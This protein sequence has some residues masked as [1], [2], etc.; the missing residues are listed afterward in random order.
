MSCRAL[1]VYLGAPNAAAYAPQDS[2]IDVLEYSPAE[3]AELLRHLETDDAAYQR[4][5]DWRTSDDNEIL[6]YFSSILGERTLDGHQEDG[7]D[8]VCKLC[9]LY[10]KHYDWLA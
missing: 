10:H 3:L 9:M 8:W 7:M 2:F 5:F 1:P 4:Y 6:T